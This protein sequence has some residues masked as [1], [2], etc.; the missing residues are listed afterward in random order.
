MAELIFGRTVEKLPDALNTQ[1]GNL[2]TRQSEAALRTRKQGLATSPELESATQALRGFLAS[3]PQTQRSAFR[4][5]STPIS[6]VTIDPSGYKYGGETDIDIGQFIGGA[7]PVDLSTIPTTAVDL[8]R[9]D[10]F[11][12]ARTGFDAQGNRIF[13]QGLP[14]PTPT[15]P[16]QAQQDQTKFQAGVGTPVQPVGTTTPPS[17]TAGTQTQNPL[18][19]LPNLTPGTTS[20]DVK[21]LQDYLVSQG[22]MTA[23]EVATGPGTYG[24]R[25]KRAVAELQKRLGLQV[26]AGQEGF[27]GPLTKNAIM[28]QQPQGQAETP[29]GG[30]NIANG[31]QDM[32]TDANQDGVLDVMQQPTPSSTIPD[33]SSTWASLGLPANLTETN[34][35]DIVTKISDAF[36]LPDI[37]KEMTDL[38]AKLAE[39][40]QEANENPWLSEGARAKKVSA[41]Q[42]K[43]ETKRQSVVDRL[44][45]QSD[46]VGKALDVFDKEREYKK[47]LLFKSLDLKAKALDESKKTTDDIREYEFA[48]EQGYA[49]TFVDYQKTKAA[50]T[51]PSSFRE[52]QLAGEPG[53]Y[54]EWLRTTGRP[55]TQAQET[56]ATYAARLEQ[57]NPTI[58]SLGDTVTKMNPLSFEAQ[59][60]LPAFLQSP[61]IQQYMQ[62]AR[63]FINATLRRE[64]GAVIAE[65]EFANAYNQYLP[66]P[67]D[68]AQTLANKKKNRDIVQ[69]SFKKGAG[70]AYQSVDE[71]LGIQ[72]NDPLGI[73]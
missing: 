4:L 58:T 44:K 30:A 45:T 24:P 72:N 67:G 54:E 62:A 27:F 56:V 42:T 29:Q 16:Q 34:I 40:I 23:E 73:R 8:N 33:E 5:T 22:L 52:W 47:D 57:S 41:I 18:A 6:G 3:V 51:T 53:T 65:S 70:P 59:I 68:T 25:T 7:R 2:L 17:A 63:N 46:I 31:G 39:E 19:N 20:Q 35:T 43:Y 14:Q 15:A 64:S 10:I 48:K 55:P 28:N 50:T 69:A 12:E 61:D 49:G 36:G 13:Q 9:Q 11:P 37:K 26:P 1:F 21:A 60:R 32:T 71:L 66:K 38:D